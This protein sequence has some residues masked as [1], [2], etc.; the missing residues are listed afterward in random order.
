LL[1]TPYLLVI[2]MVC[3]FCIKGQQTPAILNFSGND[4][5]A[6]NQNWAIG[7]SKDRFIYFANTNGLLSYN[8]NEWKL[9]K[10]HSNKII[11]SVCVVQDRI[12]TG[13]YN[14]F[15]YWIEDECKSSKYVSLT[16][17]IPGNAIE[18]EEIWNIISVGNKIYFQSFSVLMVYDGHKVEKINL[19]GSFMFLHQ[20][21]NTLIIQCLD[22]G[23]YLIN[24]NNS[25]TQINDNGFFLKKTVSGIIDISADEETATYLITTNSH[26]VFLYK[27]GKIAV[28]NEKYQ[29][30]FKDVQFNKAIL[31]KENI[32]VFGTIRDGVLFFDLAGNLIYH[33]HTTN[34]LINNTVLSIL[35]DE[36]GNIWLGLDKGISHIKTNEKIRYYNDIYGNL[37]TIYCILKKDNLL[38]VGTNQGLYYS[39]QGAN[40]DQ[41]F[42]DFKLVKGTQGQVWQLIN[43]DD[44]VICGHNEG[45]FLIEGI[46]ASKVS[47]IT[48]GWY[49]THFIKGKNILIQ[50][51]YTGIILLKKTNQKWQFLH[52]IE[53]YNTPVKK[54]IVEDSIKIWVSGPNTG[55]EL[56]T[57]DENWLNVVEQQKFTNA[58]G[59]EN[60][61]NVELNS[62]DNNIVVF[63][64]LKHYYFDKNKNKFL[65]ETYL[66][67]FTGTFLLR[68]LENDMWFR[69]YNDSTVMMN[70]RNRAAVFHVSLNK[71]YNNINWLDENSIGICI[72][73]GYC[74]VNSSP[75]EDSTVTNYLTFYKLINSKTEACLVINSEKKLKIRYDDNSFRVYFYD[76]LFQNKK[77]YYYR[78][79]PFHSDWKPITNSSFI[80]VNNI[81]PGNYT[82]EIKG[83]YN[84]KSM[85][86]FEVMKPWYFNNIAV[87]VYLIIISFLFYLFTI[88]FDRKLNREKEK[89]EAENARVIRQHM[90]EIENDRLTQDNIAK[91]KELA[92]AT[93]NLIQKNELLQ[94]IK[95]ELIEIRKTGDHTLTTKDF[96]NLMKQINTNMTTE[97][98]KILFDSN[99]NDVHDAFLKK[100]KSVY[101]SLTVADLKLAAYLRMN[102]TSKDIAPLF[103][104][105]IRGLENKR[106]RLRKKIGLSNEASL[107]E[108]FVNYE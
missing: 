98:D 55:V 4:Y 35:E 13:A 81:A 87:V 37:G 6:H 28:W 11:R 66:N 5:K 61:D 69:I 50:G 1:K 93:M 25:I 60:Y 100:I 78:I 12:Y 42:P 36:D 99:F 14:E 41:K 76:A 62:F 94:E 17:L 90:V 16:S 15:G 70:G 52:K 21:K 33:I 103:N 19:P 3:H 54:L 22:H 31:T 74:V 46:N 64:G 49:S 84:T 85:L 47:N 63:D 91:S 102:L 24:D 45:T 89:L 96:Q 30:Y 86:Q 10:L 80:E 27:D 18:K 107:T 68:E 44:S 51:T 67:A 40:K 23:L 57:L 32:L 48:G 72:N 29:N 59:L 82:L 34:G 8:G 7:Q 39:D 73:E 43:V 2:L 75:K 53:G 83:N 79:K 88:Y 101:P 71:D 108:F 77:N 92:N 9:Q 106:Y 105:S 65:P 58:D 104:I 56:L 95:E 97:E 20:I 26:G 38:Y